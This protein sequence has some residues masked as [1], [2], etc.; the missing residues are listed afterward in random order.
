MSLESGTHITFVYVRD[1]S[2]VFTL[3]MQCNDRKDLPLGTR[4]Y[5]GLQD[6]SFLD[7]G[8]MYRHLPESYIL[9]ICLFDLFGKGL[10]VYT[11]ENTCLEDRR[12]SLNDKCRKI[13]YNANAWEKERNPERRVL[14]EYFFGAAVNDELTRAMDEQVSFTRNL[15]Q[16]R[17]EHMTLEQE[18]KLQ[19]SYAYDDGFSQGIS[20]G[21]YD[22]KIEAAKLMLVNKI[23]AATVSKCTGLSADEINQIAEGNS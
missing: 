19:A 22:A 13:F 15:R 5:Q 1:S 8:N 14:L 20:Q 11:F 9:F 12:I 17:K 23:D 10:P 18:I 7:K 16:W 4:Y 6:I 21:A 3:E 2:R